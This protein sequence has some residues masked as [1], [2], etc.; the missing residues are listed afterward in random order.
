MGNGPPRG[1]FPGLFRENH[2]HTNQGDTVAV[3]TK[4]RREGWLTSWKF[5]VGLATTFVIL[6]AAVAIGAMI[7]A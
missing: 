4:P 2:R 5:W 1:P 3:K 6:F 7:A